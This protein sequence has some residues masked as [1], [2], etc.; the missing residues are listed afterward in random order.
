MRARTW[1]LL[2]AGLAVVSSVF[3]SCQQNPEPPVLRSFDRPQHLDFV[4]M[5]VRTN[6]ENRT[7][8]QPPIPMPRDRC[9]AIPANESLAARDARPFHLF[10]LVTQT[11]RG[12][13]AVVDLTRGTVIDSS[14][15]TPGMNL[16]VVGS[17]PTGLVSMPDGTAT[18]VGTADPSKP[19][20]FALPSTQILGDFYSRDA[21]AGA[22]PRTV[23]DWPVCSLPEAPGPLAVVARPGTA[24][25]YELVVV[26]SGSARSKPKIVTMDP[27]YFRPDAAGADAGGVVPFSPGQLEPCMRAI[28]STLVLDDTVPATWVPGPTWPDGIPYVDGGA[29]LTG[30]LPKLPS[31][32]GEASPTADA[33]VDADGGADGGALPVRVPAGAFSHASFAI[34]D[35]TMLYVADDGLPLVHVVDLSTPG[36]PV[37]LAPYVA[38]SLVQPDARVTVGALALSPPAR[39]YRRYLYAVDARAGSVMVFDATDPRTAPRT[40]LLRPHRELSPLQAPDRIAFEA[41]VATMTFVRTD[42]PDLAGRTGALCVPSTP[43]PKE[44]TDPPQIVG[45]DYRKGGGLTVDLGPT[46]LRGVFALL[47][48]ANGQIAVVDVDDWD[49]TCRRP[50][51]LDGTAPL[52]DLAVPLGPQYPSPYD[53]AVADESSVT[54]EAFW[55]V[56]APHRARSG[57]VLVYDGGAARN[58]PHVLNVQYYQG[59]AP[60]NLSAGKPFDVV[61]G[62]ARDVPDVA[63]DQDW[64]FVYE[65]ELPGFDGLVAPMA[66]TDGWQTL[67]L[68]RQGGGFCAR[69]VEDQRLGR[70]RVADAL[71]EQA[72]IQA[73]KGNGAKLDFSLPAGLDQAVG[74]Y[75]VLTDNLLAESDGYWSVDAACWQNIPEAT[76]A[77]G[78]RQFCKDA[79]GDLDAPKTAARSFRIREAYDDRLVLASYETQRQDGTR[80]NMAQLAQCCFHAQTRFRVRAGGEWLAIGS[81][82]GVLHDVGVDPATKACTWSCRE[83]DVLRRSRA[84]GVVVPSRGMDLPTPK[85]VELGLSSSKNSPFGVRNPFLAGLPIVREGTTPVRDANVRMQ[86]RGGFSPARI[87]LTSGTVTQV[88]PLSMTFIEPLQQ[89]AVVDGASQGLVIVDLATLKTVGTYY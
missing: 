32:C 64:R 78:R 4:C 39:D 65:G 10:A 88:S 14:Y 46:R 1:M 47:T 9:S 12:E 60:V 41:P 2:V 63:I 33:G 8:I 57:K 48:L 87:A 36:K 67:L 55:P 75:V 26:L 68:T 76:D 52:G 59:D 31:V 86:V 79:F 54:D 72:R 50:A 56:S 89:V 71:A 23:A 73:L 40:P 58:A 85:D 43:A 69:G 17:P 34:A 45:N 84:I 19:S 70:L 25:G 5:Q 15:A 49:A 82:I 74:D 24:T 53:V 77:A 13:V 22:R 66:T 30:K 20:I 18:F 61:G 37:E 42:V 62:V 81:S 6:D 80:L 27:A 44:A 51:R 28:T 29:D 7:V 35:G 38:T 16:L 11:V 83:R 21:D 3:A